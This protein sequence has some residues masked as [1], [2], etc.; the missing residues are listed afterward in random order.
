MLLQSFLIKKKYIW[1]E[2]L[3]LNQ[4]FMKEHFSENT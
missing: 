4:T 2:G 1:E 3:E